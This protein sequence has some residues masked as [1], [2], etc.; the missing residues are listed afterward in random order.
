MEVLLEK[1]T[2]TNATLTVK[3]AKEDYQPKVD[4]TLKDYSKRVNLKGFRPGKVPA[5]VI[6]RMYGKSIVIDEVN[7]LLSDT[8][9]GYIRDNK[10]PV[11]GDPQIDREKTATIDWDKQSEF[12]FAYELGLA[13]DFEVNLSTLPAVS[14]YTIEAGEKE[15]NDTIENLRTQFA[16][17][18]NPEVSEAGDM[19]YGELKQGDFS[20]KT[21]IPSRQ[22]KEEAQAQFIGLSKGSEISFDIRN[23]FV[24]DKAV[25]HLTGLKDEDAAA[26]TGDFTFTVEDVTRQ[27]PAEINQEFFDKVLGAGKV[28]N[29]EAFRDQV[30]EIIKNN[31]AREADTLLRRDIDQ[32]LLDNIN[33]DLP[34]EFLKK[35]LFTANEGKF[36]P[37][38]I[39][40]DYPQFTK[41]L[42]LSL[43]KNKMAEQTDIKVES[44]EVIARA[45]DMVREQFGF[46][47][48]DMG[49]QMNDTI[50]KIAMNYLTSEKENNY[51]KMF[52]LVFDDKVFATLKTQL[53]LEDK[54][55]D[56]E[57]FQE[58]VKSLS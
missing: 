57:Q 15:L 8:V 38:Q 45:E 36:T 21:A 47:G 37:E 49:E 44:E 32:T 46:Y 52:N 19:I 43:I 39:D 26:L 3:L 51:S 50:R 5:Q 25:A 16:G 58:I 14:N 35:W 27:A 42:K 56:V 22:I 1:S 12:E 2:P 11:V 28:D 9:S 17:Q 31:Y 6:Q 40:A 20:T 7:Q 55:I 48:N 29:E 41:S 10:L 4:K 33:I 18:I 13:S 54:T 34:E 53:P 23:T 24:D 30:A